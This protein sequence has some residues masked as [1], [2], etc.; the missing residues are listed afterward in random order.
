VRP[1]GELDELGG[2][3]RAAWSDLVAGEL[4]RLIK[5]LA[6]SKRKPRGLLREG[7]AP[8]GVRTIEWPAFPVR[9]AAKHGAVGAMEALDRPL[10]EGPT[11]GRFGQEEYLEWRL[12]R[13]D[14]EPRGIEMTTE[15]RE[16][17]TVLAAH[18]PRRTLKLVGK[19]AGQ[20]GAVAATEV[21]GEGMPDPLAPGIGPPERKAAFVGTMLPDYDDLS[22]EVSPC[23]DGRKALCCMVQ[24]DN[25]LEAL[26]ALVL[27]AAR[28]LV[29][30]DEITGQ[31]R[32]PSGSEA[33]VQLGAEA[34]DGRNSDPLIV[35]RVVRF[36]SEGRGVGVDDPLG[37]YIRGLQ[38]H[39]LEQPGGEDVPRAWLELSRGTSAAKSPDG[40]PRHQRLKLELPED[41]DFSL[42]DL[43]VRRSGERL[44]LGGQLAEL[45]ELGAYIA[46]GPVRKGKG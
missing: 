37:V 38:L 45:V 8:A 41:A 13:R 3:G 43:R 4:N 23:N 35:E 11:G 21:Y 30:K 2:A 5:E 24:S 7:E 46:A 9:V 12:L 32:Y 19:L 18:E 10:G 44:R 39:E 40:R 16:Y 1:P 14:G 28:P 42:A 25:N 20:K 26:L 31:K 6:K 34:L 29:V 27:S 33:I 15:F 22:R 36:V 17:W